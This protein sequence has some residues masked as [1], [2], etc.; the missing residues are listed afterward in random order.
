MNEFSNE[1]KK[2]VKITNNKISNNEIVKDNSNWFKVLLE[3]NPFVL[4][5]MEAVNDWVFMNFCAKHSCGLVYT[6]SVDCI[7]R[8]IYSRED[9]A[10]VSCPVVL[11]LRVNS[12]N[13]AKELINYFDEVVS[14][15][16]LSCGCPK[17]DILGE[18]KGGYLLTQPRKLGELI[19]GIIALTSK[20]VSVK[21]RRGFDEKRDNFLEVAKEVELAG[22]SAIILHPRFVKQGYRGRADWSCFEKV[23]KSISIPFIINGDISSDNQATDFLK[24]NVCDGVMFGREAMSNPNI[25]SECLSEFTKEKGFEKN[26]SNKKLIGATKV[27]FLCED[28]LSFEGVEALSFG[29]LVDHLCWFVK[30]L[31]NAKEVRERIRSC[32]TIDE[33]KEVIRKIK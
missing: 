28:F 2:N 18:K 3:K 6:Q 31:S 14:A 30:S 26:S 8:P 21:I 32:E 9:L 22:A 4:A 16:D 33:I 1:Y 12:L 20:P 11:Q 25:F 19:K 13:K 23:R 17:G 29:Q 10:K 15:Y 27:K 5:P 24:R 7:S